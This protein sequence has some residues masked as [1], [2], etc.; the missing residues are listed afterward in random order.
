LGLGIALPKGKVRVFKKDT[1]GELEFVGE[2]QIGPHT[3]TRKNYR[4]ISAMLSIL[5]LNIKLQTVKFQQQY[6]DST[7]QME[8]RSI[9]LRNRKDAAVNN[10][11]R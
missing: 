6:R 4:F 9:E 5:P 8:K 11:C 10:I 2:D 1:D 3:P 7:K